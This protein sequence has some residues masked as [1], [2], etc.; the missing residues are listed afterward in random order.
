[1]HV[2]RVELC[3]NNGVG[4]GGVGDAQTE[5]TVLKPCS[6]IDG[7]EPVKRLVPLLVRIAITP[8][9]NLLGWDCFLPYKGEVTPG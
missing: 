3:N 7:G 2:S 8:V 1:M 6:G 5:D 4:P 9:D